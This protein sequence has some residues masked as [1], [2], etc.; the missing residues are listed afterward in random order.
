MPSNVKA[1]FAG[2]DVFRYAAYANFELR[3]LETYKS[4]HMQAACIISAHRV[5]RSPSP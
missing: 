3:L 4:G 5:V 1:M 2:P